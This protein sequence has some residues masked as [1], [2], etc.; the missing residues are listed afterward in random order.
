MVMPRNDWC[1]TNTHIITTPV[2]MLAEI[3]IVDTPGINAIIREHETITSQFVPRSDLVLFVTLRR[4][5][6]Y[7]SEQPS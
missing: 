1:R 2:E 3:S 7:E 5:P 6:L 4:S